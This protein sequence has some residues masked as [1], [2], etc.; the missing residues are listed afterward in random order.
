M[1]P[2]R[3]Y[4][5]TCGQADLAYYEETDFDFGAFCIVGEEEAVYTPRNAEESPLYQAVVKNLETFLFDHQ[6][7]DRPVPFFVEREMR[8]FLDCGIPSHGFIRVHCD[9]CG[10]DRIVPFSCKGRGFCSSCGGRRMAD[11]A[12]HL[13]DR[14][15]PE[16]PTRQWVLTLPYALRFL[17]AY[18]S[19]LITAINSIFVQ[20]VFTSLRRRARL[21]H[22]GRKARGGAVVFIQRFGDAL[23]LNVHFHMLAFDGV[24]AEDEDGFIR[25][26]VVGPPSDAEVLRLVERI[27]RRVEKLMSREGLNI[28]A[29][30]DEQPFLAELYGSAV[31]GRIL[32]GPNAGRQTVRAGD[33]ENGHGRDEASSPRCVNL[34]GVGLHA[35]TAI[36]A[37]DRV[38][39]ERM[40][41]YMCR[42]PIALE[43]LKMLSDG[44]L[45]YKLKKHWRDGTSRVIFQPLEMMERLAAL[46]PAPRFNL[47]RYCG[48]LAP[49]AAWRRI[50]IP[51]EENEGTE[52]AICKGG[53]GKNDSCSRPRHYGWAE[54]LKRVFSVDVLKCDKCAGRM[55][56]L[57]AV[58]PPTAIRKIL[59]CIGLPS[60]PPPISPALLRCENGE[61]APAPA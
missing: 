42:P 27:A 28:D 13:V 46:V 26:H 32:S 3:D 53:S 61:T 10:H 25:F 14:V 55:R 30:H 18:D 40:C 24:Y 5:M 6:Q 34:N 22:L 33:I 54:L 21:S 44:R 45:Q 57:C 50:I 19:K 58:N 15:L 1:E 59:D 20:A 7:R 43:R 60:R 56:I 11:T 52:T 9:S 39:L 2:L 48:V 29:K 36:P 37:R 17:M 16:V 23:N 8:A 12:A 49:S 38:R 41:R 51:K 47:I 35:N 4:I 31:K